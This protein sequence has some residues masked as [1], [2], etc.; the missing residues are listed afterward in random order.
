MKL[1]LKII[2]KI[3]KWFLIILAGLLATLFVT[4]FTVY[5]LNLDGKLINKKYDEM[6][7]YFDDMERDSMI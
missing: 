6:Q 3:L 7:S 1:F 5:M 4:T 2:L